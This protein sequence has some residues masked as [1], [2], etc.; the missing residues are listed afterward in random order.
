MTAY[1][2]PI[3][4]IAHRVPDYFQ[5]DDQDEKV[6]QRE[7]TVLRS[8]DAD[9]GAGSG[10]G[11]ADKPQQ[12]S[13]ILFFNR[14]P[15]TGSGSFQILLGKLAEIH[16]YSYEPSIRFYRRQREDFELVRVSWPQ[17]LNGDYFFQRV[18]FVP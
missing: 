7:W 14:V 5:R 17:T 12:L 18:P 3:C 2:T 10:G 1:S 8:G 13:E 15:K 11:G 16:K 6:Q 4:V 9:S